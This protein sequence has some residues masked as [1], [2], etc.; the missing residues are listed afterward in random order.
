[1]RCVKTVTSLKIVA[2]RKNAKRSTGPRTERGRSIACIEDDR[3]DARF[4][5]TSLLPEGDMDSL[6]AQRSSGSQLGTFC[7][8]VSFGLLCY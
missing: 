6:A 5:Y 3:S 8:L 2:N 7:S 1:M 4:D